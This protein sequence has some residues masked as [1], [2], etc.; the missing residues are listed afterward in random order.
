MDNEEYVQKIKS[1]F[2]VEDVNALL[3]GLDDLK[4]LLIGDAIIDE[5]HFTVPKGRAIK[6]PIMSV[7]YL[8][9]EVYL[10]GILIIANHISNF[11]NKVSLI[12]LMGDTNSRADFIKDSLNR[13]INAK[14]FV[15]NDASTTVKT[16]FIDYARG[17]K[18]FKIEHINDVPISEKLESEIIDALK[19][20]LPKYDLVVV[21]DFGHGFITDKIIRTLE[22]YSKYIT[23]NVQTNSSNYGFNFITKYGHVNFTSMDE[24]EMKLA[25]VSRFESIDTMM[26]RL[27][28][29]GIADKILI[30]LGS[31]GCAYMDNSEEILKCPILTHRVIDTV[32]AGDAVFSIMSL[33]TYKGIPKEL[34]P[35]I[36]N[37]VGGIAVNIIGNKESITKEKLLKFIQRVYDGLE[38]VGD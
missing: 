23:L 7:D 6:D 20:E 33:L 37:C 31:K 28:K 16:R 22:K 27:A 32:G 30:T 8:N 17:H 11:T 18:L 36:S 9:H 19:K 21:G 4:V 25:L 10:G 24:N 13:N 34:V 15:K 2:I 35:F 3:E 5:Y 38:P 1:K 29:M 12:S 26:I 14:F